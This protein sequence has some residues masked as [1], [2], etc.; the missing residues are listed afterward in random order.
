MATFSM[1]QLH[2]YFRRSDYLIDKPLLPDLPGVSSEEQPYLVV[3]A[4]DFEE[5]PNQDGSA[6]N[7]EL[8]GARVA[9]SWL[10]L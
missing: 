3:P 4:V 6:V 1:V 7:S 8:F 2:P 10:V 5:T 9:C